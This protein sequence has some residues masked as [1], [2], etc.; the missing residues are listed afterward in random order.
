MRLARICP[1]EA[2]HS[3]VLNNENQ[4][5]AITHQIQL[6]EENRFLIFRTLDAFPALACAIGG[7]RAPA[8]D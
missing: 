6:N 3:L 7:G 5:P 4:F 2:S 1:A 8:I